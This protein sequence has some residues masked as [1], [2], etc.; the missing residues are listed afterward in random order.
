MNEKSL[1][2]VFSTSKYSPR[3]ENMI[4]EYMDDEINMTLKN[5]K[6]PAELERLISEHTKNN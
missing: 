2:S 6:K 1:D 4:W 5:I 3:K